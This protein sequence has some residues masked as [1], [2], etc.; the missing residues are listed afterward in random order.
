MTWNTYMKTSSSADEY[1]Y[2]SHLLNR[3]NDSIIDMCE[4][5]QECKDG[6][7]K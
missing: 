2:F 7:E 5:D 4:D 3:F 6:R 1:N